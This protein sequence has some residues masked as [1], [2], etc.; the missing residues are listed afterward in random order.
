MYHTTDTP[1]SQVDWTMAQHEAAAAA[2]GHQV[3]FGMRL[4]SAPRPPVTSEWS[5]AMEAG[6]E[7]MVDR[8]LID[9]ARAAARHAFA[10]MDEAEA[11]AATL[12]QAADDERFAPRETLDFQ[13]LKWTVTEAPAGGWPEAGRA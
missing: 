8:I 6:A 10:A 2:L 7:I 9:T 1:G 13:S 4:W 12:A 11:L 3:A 5:R